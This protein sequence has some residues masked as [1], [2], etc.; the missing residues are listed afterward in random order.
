[1]K[2]Q[3]DNIIKQKYKIFEE[4]MIAIL[5]TGSINGYD[6]KWIDFYGFMV[7]QTLKGIRL[8]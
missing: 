3:I 2:I 4:I 1:M 7:Q 6:H 8:N 5:I